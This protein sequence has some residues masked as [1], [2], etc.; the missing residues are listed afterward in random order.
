MARFMKT[1]VGSMGDRKYD[2]T[3]ELGEL[4]DH[5]ARRIS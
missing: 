1:R 3:D 4:Y 2:V 5:F